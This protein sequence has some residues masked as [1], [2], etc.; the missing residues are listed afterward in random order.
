[1]GGDDEYVICVGLLQH[2]QGMCLFVFVLLFHSY[3]LCS[4]FYIEHNVQYQSKNF[5]EIRLV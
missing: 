1:M 2:G 3:L 4:L 5:M